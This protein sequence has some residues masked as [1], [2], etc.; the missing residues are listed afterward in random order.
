MMKRN[1]TMKQ[2]EIEIDNLMEVINKDN[3]L[4]DV[5]DFEEILSQ[6]L[7]MING[8]T[9]SD[10]NGH[11]GHYIFLNIDSEYDD[12]ETWNLIEKTIKDHINK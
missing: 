5:G 9:N 11:F 12:S 10:Y 3:E 6:K 8:I 4:E 2:Y 1:C 7:D